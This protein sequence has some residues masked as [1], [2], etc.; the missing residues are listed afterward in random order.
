MELNI[1]FTD[2]R[3]KLSFPWRRKLPFKSN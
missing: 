1:C 3:G 2:K